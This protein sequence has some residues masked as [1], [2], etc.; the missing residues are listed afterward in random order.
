MDDLEL[1]SDAELC[2]LLDGVDSRVLAELYRRHG[3]SVHNLARHVCGSQHFADGVTQDVFLDLWRRPSSFDDTR[4]SLRT[5]LITRAHGKSVDLVRAESARQQRERRSASD[6]ALAGYDLDR[7]VV[8][9]STAERVRRIVA[10][11]PQDERAAIHL[12]YFEGMTYREVAATLGAPEG[13]VKSRIRSGLRRLRDAL[14]KE[15]VG[16]P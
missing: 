15:G 3:A 6:T 9:L 2:R 13:T 14:R 4:A 10:Q 5:Y 11:L 16:S 7:F 12:A 8:D 1:K